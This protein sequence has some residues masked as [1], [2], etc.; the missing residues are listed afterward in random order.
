MHYAALFSVMPGAV[1]ADIPPCMGTGVVWCQLSV[2]HH[3]ELVALARA[4]CEVLGR[5]RYAEQR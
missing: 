3:V 5:W 4:V 1:W 2:P